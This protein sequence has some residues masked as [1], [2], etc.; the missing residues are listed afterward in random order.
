MNTQI[1]NVFVYR[2]VI[3]QLVAIMKKTLENAFVGLGEMF[4][5]VFI[6]MNEP[7]DKVLV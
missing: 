3:K 1:E 7:C 2:D 5:H 4:Q 6:S